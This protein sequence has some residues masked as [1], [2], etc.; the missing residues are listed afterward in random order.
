MTTYSDEEKAAAEQKANDLL[1]QFEAGE[2]TEDAFAALATENT[3]DPGS[4]EN[5]GLY[6][7]VYR[8][9]MVPTFNDWVFD[10]SRKAGDTGV[11]G[12]EYGYHVMY[13]CGDGSM[14][15]RDSMIR[16]ELVTADME[17]WSQTLLDAVTTVD[18]DVSL[19]PTNMILG[20]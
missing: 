6:E 19:I 1:S 16:N 20:R 4:K 13:F 18:G 3:M 17:K 12:T 11:V 7:N 10:S 14:S 2:K 8:G 15:Y 5:G 9:Q